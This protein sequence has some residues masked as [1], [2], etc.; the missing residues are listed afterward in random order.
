MKQSLSPSR[1]VTQLA[2]RAVFVLYLLVLGFIVLWPSHVDD[3]TAGGFVDALM[4]RGH[5][6]GWLP[7]WFTY[8]VLEW[9][10][11]VVMF[12]PFGF[13]LVWL[14]RPQLRSWILVWGFLL[15]CAIESTQFFMPDRTS[16]WLDILANTLGVA[17][18]LLLAVFIKRCAKR[19]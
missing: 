7:L 15:T 9:L 16:S 17:L 8:A 14:V 12:T 1:S 19:P 6:E 5:T 13:L 10:S 18:G 2:P 3:N 11:N 4:Q